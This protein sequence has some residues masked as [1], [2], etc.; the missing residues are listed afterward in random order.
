MASNAPGVSRSFFTVHHGAV[1]QGSG[2]AGAARSTV[3]VSVTHEVRYTPEGWPQPLM[4]DIYQPAGAGPFPAVMMVHGGGW[5]GGKRQHMHRT[6]RMV[7]AQGH[8]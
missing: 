6:A 8:V 1:R 7:A 2:V 3:P 4:A 5:T